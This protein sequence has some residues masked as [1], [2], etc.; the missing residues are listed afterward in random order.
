[1][2]LSFFYII[3]DYGRACLE[4]CVFVNSIDLFYIICYN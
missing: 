4:V 3:G 1:M 2:P